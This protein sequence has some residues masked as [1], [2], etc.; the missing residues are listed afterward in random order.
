MAYIN[1]SKDPLAHRLLRERTDAGQV[2]VAMQWNTS[3]GSPCSCSPATST[4]SRRNPCRA[5]ARLSRHAEQVRATRDLR[6]EEDNLEART[7]AGALAVI[8][9]KLQNPQFEGQTKSARQPVDQRPRRVHR[10]RRSCRVPRRTRPMRADRQQ[11]VAASRARMAA[12]KARADAPE[13][14]ARRDVSPG[15]AGRLLDQRS[16]RRSSSSS[17]ATR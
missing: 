7:S 5:S 11:G 6:G 12:R 16:G 14:G 3:T 1:D 8:S 17:R 13:V 4:P 9:V 15:Q 10:E 2:E